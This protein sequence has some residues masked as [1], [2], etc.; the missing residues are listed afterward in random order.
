MKF[1][2]ITG[3]TNTINSLRE[4]VDTD[5]IPHAMLLGGQEG[6]GKMRVARA[7]ISYLYCMDRHEGDSCGKCPAC[8]QNAH[9]NNPDVHFIF[10]RTGATTKSTETFLPQWYDFLDSHSYMPKEEWARAI[11]AG[12]TV[13][14]IYRSDA[15]E[16]SRTASLSSF[17]YRYKT[18]VIWMPERMQPQCANALLKLLEEPFPDTIFI[19]VSNEPDKLLPTIFSRTQRFNLKPLT[20]AEVAEI[21]IQEGTSGNEAREVAA[22]AE[23]NIIKA[24]DMTGEGGEIREFSSI[25][26]QMMRLAYARNVASLRMLSESIAAMGREKTAR[27]LAYCARMTRESFIFNL[28]TEGLNA[29]TRAEADF[30]VRFSPFINHRNVERLMTEIQRAHDDVLRNA[31]ARLVLFDFMLKVMMQLRNTNLPKNTN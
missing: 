14:V 30:N 5:H 29:M 17:A 2:E 24:F 25:F 26:I 12:N 7:F 1:S 27:F 9:H 20:D 21:L 6:I 10:P 3:H 15:S 23:G 8:L 19:L 22:L 11:E 4:A 16:I 13:P 28:K 18:Y 31:N